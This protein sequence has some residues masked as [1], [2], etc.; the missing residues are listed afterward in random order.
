MG[1]SVTFIFKV[2]EG[3]TFSL[4][5]KDENIT[6]HMHTGPLYTPLLLD[7]CGN[8]AEGLQGC[9]AYHVL[10]QGEVGR[11]FIGRILSEHLSQFRE[12]II[13]SQP[14]SW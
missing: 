9:L 6:V 8:T 7:I 4:R 14:H 11:D 12:A 1:G 2:W 5:C 10:A 13:C 3:L